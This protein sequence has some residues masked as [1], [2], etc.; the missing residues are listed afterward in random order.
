MSTV[1]SCICDHCENGSNYQHR[2]W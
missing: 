2:S 1:I